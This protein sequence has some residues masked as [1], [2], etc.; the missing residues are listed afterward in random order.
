MPDENGN[1]QDGG[2]NITITANSAAGENCL[3][4]LQPASSS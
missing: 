4:A 2:R 3:T 1:E